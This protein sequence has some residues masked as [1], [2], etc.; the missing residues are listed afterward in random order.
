MADRWFDPGYKDDVDRRVA[1]IIGWE[2]RNWTWYDGER[3]TDYLAVE[4]ISLVGK[5]KWT[6]TEYVE[7]ALEAAHLV[8]DRRWMPFTLRRQ[9]RNWTAEF[10]MRGRPGEC[11]QTHVDAARAICEAILRL[12]KLPDPNRLFRRRR[13]DPVT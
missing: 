8:S 10:H 3:E 4:D 13:E 2:L 9:D 12:G 1:E 5:H 11:A 6:P 7:E